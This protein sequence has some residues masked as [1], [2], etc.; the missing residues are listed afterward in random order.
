M[1]YSL[2]IIRVI[3]ALFRQLGLKNIPTDLLDLLQITFHTKAGMIKQH[4][5][6]H[7]NTKKRFGSKTN[8]NIKKL[9]ITLGV[10]EFGLCQQYLPGKAMHS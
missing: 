8:K 9:A 3:I 10:G 1:K 7:L 6:L 2:I 4:Y 5:F